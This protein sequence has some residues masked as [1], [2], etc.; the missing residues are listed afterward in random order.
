MNMEEKIREDGPMSYDY[1]TPVSAKDQI[2]AR[3]WLREK[4]REISEILG[5]AKKK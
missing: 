4:D 2:E 5:K 1:H 3:R